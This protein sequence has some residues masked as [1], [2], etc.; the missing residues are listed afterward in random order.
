MLSVLLSLFW[1]QII[2][3]FLMLFLLILKIKIMNDE[4]RK[5]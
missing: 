1:S 3:D 5:T 2:F 4:K